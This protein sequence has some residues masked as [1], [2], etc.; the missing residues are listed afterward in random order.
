MGKKIK[1]E[2]IPLA[3][4]IAFPGFLRNFEIESQCV[5]ANQN[6]LSAIRA[7][8]VELA[9]KGRKFEKGRK[10]NTVSPIRK[11]IA[12]ALCD[13]PDVTNAKLWN[14]IK[15]APPEDFEVLENKLGKYIEGPGMQSMAYARF[16]NVASEERRR[17]GPDLT[18]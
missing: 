6:L 2:S 11:Y 8:L 3:A 4:F 13:S 9:V 18:G 12:S 14:E 10:V 5:D 7:E 17:L 15:L 16:C 1:P